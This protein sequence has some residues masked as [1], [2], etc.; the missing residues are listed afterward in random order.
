MKP[1]N[2]VI[3]VAAVLIVLGVAIGSIARKAKAKKSGCRTGCIGC[4][5]AGSCHSQRTKPAD[6]KAL[7]AKGEPTETDD[8]T[9]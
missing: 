3:I 8:V 7:I 1:I 5:Y 6:V 2:V 9:K 4:P